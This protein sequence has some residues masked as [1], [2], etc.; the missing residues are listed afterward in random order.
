MAR[1]VKC[2][3]DFLARCATWPVT[4]RSGS[5]WSIEGARSSSIARSSRAA[6][7][8][9]AP[10]PERGRSRHRAARDAEEGGKAAEGGFSLAARRDRNT[11]I[12][13]VADDGR[14][15]DEAR[16]GPRARAGMGRDAE[17]PDLLRILG[18]PASAPGAR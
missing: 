11:V 9:A 5:V 6:Q 1:S 4:W 14:G 3:S 10:A 13:T 12:I 2:S 18:R 7:D 15:I 8:S 17:T 16:F